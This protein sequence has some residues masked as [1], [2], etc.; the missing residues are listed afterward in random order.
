MTTLADL[1]LDVQ[2]R[3]GDRN[4][5]VWTLGAITLEIQNAYQEV[6]S[7]Q[8]VFWDVTYLE[9]LPPGFSYTA[10]WE[11]AYL[12]AMGGF[13]FG[14][15][16]FTAEIDR[17][18]LG[19][20]RTRIGP[21]TH[22][23]PFEATDG[24]LA[25]VGASTTIPATA[26]LPKILTALERVTWDNRVID[27]LS[28]RRL[29]HG[30]SRYEIT[31]GEVYGYTWQ[32]DGIR[33]LRKVRA[34]AAQAATV[35]VTG[36]WGILRRPTDLSTDTVT[37]TW[38]VPRRIPGHHPMGPEAFGLPRRPFLEGTNVR[39]EFFRHGRPLDTPTAVS[40]L[41]APYVRYLRDYAQWQLLARKG[42]GHDAKL[43]E[44][45]HQRWLRGMARIVVRL[46]HVDRERTAVLGGDGRTL[47]T[48]PPR[49]S[50][51]WAYGATVR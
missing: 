35:T 13:D 39:V 19:D 3:L 6:S 16:N 22:T 18:A 38:G 37:G 45:F 14:C 8:Q 26:E 41:P 4:E 20:E 33:T 12:V 9:N 11:R 17:R 34:P 7:P 42:P 29:Q 5:A 24:W 25:R 30:D 28:P 32:K 15:A 50:R 27:A 48:R 43:A 2:T 49:P 46:D 40:E 23:S 44:H 31:R 47:T 51:P 36:S 10:P 1:V 21:A